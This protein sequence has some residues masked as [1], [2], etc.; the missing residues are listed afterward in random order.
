MPVRRQVVVVGGGMV[1]LTL[2]L[3]L[4]AE[5]IQPV[6]LERNDT[7]GLGSRSICQAKRTLEIWNRFGG[8]GDRI[9]D[10]GVTW[11]TGKVFLGDGLLYEFNLLPEGGH[12]M[13]AFVNLQQYLVE[14]LL[15]AELVRRGADIRWQH[16]AGTLT[17]EDD[18]VS[19]E[20]G[21]PDGGYRLECEWL[22]ACDGA[23]SGVRRQLGLTPEGEVF[24]DKFL[25]SDVRMQAPFPAERRFWFEPPFHAGQTALL[26]RQADDLW[27]ID[28]QLGS[29]VDVAVEKE[30][31][32]VRARIARMLGPDIAFELVWTSIYVFQCRTLDRYVHGRVLVAGDAAHQMSPF[33]ARGGNAGVQDAD[34]LAWKLARVL[35][36]TAGPALLDS[37]EA[38]RVA[39]VR[40]DI[41]H[42]SRATTFMTPA[43]SS[44]RAMRDAALRLASEDPAFRGLIN[45]G[46][47]ST[48]SHYPG[49]PL[50]TADSDRFPPRLAPGSP[51]VDA[52]ISRDNVP[53]WLLDQFGGRFVLLVAAGGIPVPNSLAAAGERIDVMRIGAGGARDADGLVTSRYDLQPGTCYLIRPDQYVC[54]RTRSF[55]PAWLERAV[56]T[57]LG[58]P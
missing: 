26:H 50:N 21:T 18:H 12:R 45:S 10:R 9:R 55:D 41:L 28:L 1:G 36:G 34:N 4:L 30:P 48:P 2:A 31:E 8:V 5:G 20:V 35:R 37:Y 51:A 56:C 24:A 52:P 39:G 13:P 29:D 27:R 14:E 23:G 16:A 40:H 17:S 15:V 7:L 49:S 53:G 38:E 25:I 22:V 33:G 6:V 42:S 54:A 57:A 43:T 19:V 3:E 44:I 11:N 32:R 46:R 47:L 58:R